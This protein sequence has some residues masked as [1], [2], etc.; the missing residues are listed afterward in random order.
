MVHEKLTNKRTSIKESSA[1]LGDIWA[2]LSLQRGKMTKKMLNKAIDDPSNIQCGVQTC[3][4]L[5]VRKIAQEIQR[6]PM[7]M[8]TNARN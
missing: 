7:T 3:S 1:V 6:T 4:K 8:S 2:T 5:W